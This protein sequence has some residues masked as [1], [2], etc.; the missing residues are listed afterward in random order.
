M[1]ATLSDLETELAQV[2]AAKSRILEVGQS[3][4]I[5][6]RSIEE[7]SY[8]ELCAREKALLIEI[9]R[10]NGSRRRSWRGVPK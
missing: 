7:V 3:R 9:D 4:D 2:R 1:P 10:L 6:S 8:E 5:N